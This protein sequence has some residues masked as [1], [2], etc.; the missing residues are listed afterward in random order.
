[1]DQGAFLDLTLYVTGDALKE[2]KNLATIP[3]STW[4]NSSFKG[5]IYGVP[6]PL[7]RN[8]NIG[9]YRSDWAKKVGLA[10]PAST[11]DLRALLLA[12]TKKDPDGNGQARYLGRHP[13]RRRLGGLGYLHHRLQ[14][15]RDA[16]Q[17]ARQR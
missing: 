3:A 14:P 9:F 8:G 5:K 1:M 12:F 2:Y 16:V 10:A 13:L 17:L 4:K 11:D 6:R 7:Q 15:L